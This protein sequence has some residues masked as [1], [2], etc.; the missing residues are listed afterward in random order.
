MARYPCPNCERVFS[1]RSSLRNHARTHD[2][3][4]DRALQEI[5]EDVVHE[6]HDDEQ[7]EMNDDEQLEMADDE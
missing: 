6:E 7:P 2:N 3:V 4:V 1:R 5:S